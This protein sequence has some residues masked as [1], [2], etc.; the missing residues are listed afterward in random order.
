MTL[1]PL[2]VSSLLIFILIQFLLLSKILQ[3][4]LI[5]KA[6]FLLC[7]TNVDAKLI[8]NV[9]VLFVFCRKAWLKLCPF[10]AS[11]LS[12]GVTI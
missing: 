5:L 2:K 6:Y 7:F 3:S 9:V 1:G 10:A 11:S 8:F 12:R 4:A